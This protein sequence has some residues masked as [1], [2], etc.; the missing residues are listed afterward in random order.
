MH[1]ACSAM[2]NKG[3]VSDLDLSLLFF[4]SSTILEIV[5]D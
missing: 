4:L 3:F 2:S 5:T 1:A